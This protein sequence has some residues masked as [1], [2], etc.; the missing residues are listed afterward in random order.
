MFNVHSIH[1][2]ELPGNPFI[3]NCTV[4]AYCNTPLRK[5]T[6]NTLTDKFMKNSFIIYGIN[7]V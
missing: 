6:I 1:F 2:F 5:T 7:H 3:A 4:G